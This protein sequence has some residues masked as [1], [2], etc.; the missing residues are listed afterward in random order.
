MRKAA[1]DVVR[2]SLLKS[3][4]SFVIAGW[5]YYSSQIFLLGAEFTWVFAHSHGSKAGTRG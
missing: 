5:M 4:S 3:A 2:L 1:E